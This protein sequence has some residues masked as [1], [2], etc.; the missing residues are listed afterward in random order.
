MPCDNYLTVRQCINT[1]FLRIAM[2]SRP[3]M[4]RFYFNN[5]AAYMSSLYRLATD[6]EVPAQNDR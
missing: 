3:E 4:L 1:Y 6:S 5:D 2:R